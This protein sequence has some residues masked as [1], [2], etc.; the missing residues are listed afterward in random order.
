MTT[1]WH[2][3]PIAPGSTVRE[4][5]AGAFFAADAVSEPGE[6][7]V[8]EGIQNSLDA[9]LPGRMAYVRICL[10]TDGIDRQEA[11]LYFAGARTHY[12]ADDNGLRKEDLPEETEAISALVFED[13]ETSG[14]QGDPATPYPPNERG[15]NNFFHF[16]RA[17]GRSDKEVGKR[18]SWGL[19]KDTFFRASRVNTVFGL[20]VR[21]DDSRRL[22]MGKTVL[23]PHWVGEDYCQ[24]GYFGVTV[25]GNSTVLPIEGQRWH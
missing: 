19:G 6:A 7:L 18:G 13:F 23:K 16:F 3:Q 8:R 4:P 11:G 17:E 25:E 2:F 10:V 12:A 24:D 15:E 5:I 1:G 22:L 20:T 9:A 21:N 14:L